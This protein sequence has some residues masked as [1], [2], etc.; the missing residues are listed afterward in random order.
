MSQKIKTNN[1][2]GLNLRK[3]RKQNKLTQEQVVAKLQILGFDMSRSIYAQIECG[4]YNIRITELAA[5][6]DIFST[7]YDSFFEGIEVNDN[8]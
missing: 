4:T 3:L 6:K 2:F 5:L 7:T 1:Q 8:L